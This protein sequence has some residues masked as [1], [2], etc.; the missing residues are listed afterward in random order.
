VLSLARIPS[1]ALA[2]SLAGLLAL[3]TLPAQEAP[4]GKLHIEIIEGEGAT[5]NIR[6]R[7][8]REPIVEV[9]DENRKPLAGATVVFLLP[10]SGASGVFPNGARMLTA[11]TD[12]N[13]RAAATGLRPNSVAGKFQIRVSANHQGMTGSAVINQTNVMALAAVTAGGVSA[14]LIGILVGV[15]AAAAGGAL[16][17]TRS[18]GN[19]G[20]PAPTPTPT[21]TTVSISAGAPNVGP[22]PR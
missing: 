16:I 11:M 20:T 18:G 19:G 3:P 22:P 14:K 6:Q 9:Q 4:K 15:G 5:N 17:A 21:R 13:G 8:A 1:R 2:V 10:E 7:L 12:A